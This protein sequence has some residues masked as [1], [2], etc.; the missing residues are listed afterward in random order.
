[1]SID[2]IELTSELLSS[3]ASELFFVLSVLTSG[4]F[5]IKMRLSFIILDFYGLSITFMFI[6]FLRW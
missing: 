6:D 2:V 4:I 3:S 1:M 5:A